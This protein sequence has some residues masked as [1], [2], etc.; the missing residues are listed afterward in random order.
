MKQDWSQRESLR[1]PEVDMI[2]YVV[3]LIFIQTLIKVMFMFIQSLMAT[4]R[5]HFRRLK[6]FYPI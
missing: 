4:Y 2:D 1:E 6:T 3:V 5:T